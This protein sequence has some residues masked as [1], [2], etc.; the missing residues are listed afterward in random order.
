MS[1]KKLFIALAGNPNVGKSTLFNQLTGGNQHVGNWPGKT[2]AIKHGHFNLNNTQVEII[3]LPGTYSFSSYSP[4]E[5]ITRE[6]LFDTPPDLVINV[7]DSSNFERNLY[8]TVQ[9]LETGIPTILILNMQDVAVSRGI[10]IDPKELSQSLGGIPVILSSENDEEA[11]QRIKKTISETYP[12]INKIK[13]SYEDAE[14]EDKKISDAKTRYE[15]VS[16]V[17]EK[18]VVQEEQKIAFSEKVDNILTNRFLGI[19]IFLT[20]MYLV[21]NLVQNV[22]APFLNWLDYLFTGPI[23]NW[24]STIL[25]LANAPDW[26]VSLFQD[27]IIAGIGGVLV[28]L[29]SLFMM[30]LLLAIL[31]HSGYLARAAFVMDKLMSKIGLHGKSFIPMILGF[32]CNVPAIYATRT[33]KNPKARIL[34]ALLIP[35]MSCSARLPVYMIFSIAFFPNNSNIIVLI[36]YLSGIM[37]A[38]LVGTIISKLLFKG[39]I[40]NILVMELPNF[41]RPSVKAVFKYA[42]RQTKDFL[43][44]AGTVIALTSIVLWFLLNMPNGVQNPKDS[45]FGSIGQAIAPVFEPAG[46]GSWEASGALL[47]GLSAKEA[48]ISSFYQ[49]YN[50][51][52]HETVADKTTFD[53]D[54]KEIGL[55]FGFTIVESGKEILNTLTPGID[56]FKEDSYDL[57]QQDISLISSLNESFTTLSAFSFLIFVL[58]Y[59]PCVPT[60]GAIKQE[61]GWKWTSLSIFNSLA[62]PWLISIMVFQIGKLLGLG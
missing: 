26:L 60:I 31:E 62:A 43:K 58:L 61:F 36:M 9:I 51:E 40:L 50:I 54:L 30:F 56:L 57:Q 52:E 22:S 34:T 23:S 37:V 27:G 5:E 3:D 46:F 21:F 16:N 47:A 39:E 32:G 49:I 18:A 19:P 1:K 25:S 44:K 24:A 17:V 55:S 45:Y 28:F 2:V 53:E 20:I 48:V 42:S 15:F 59:I 29:P 38:G 6:F 8:L 35:F 12:K 7:V 14:G 4:E 10:T 13:L 33:L 41:R 11:I